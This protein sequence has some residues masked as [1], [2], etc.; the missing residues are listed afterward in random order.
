MSAEPADPKRASRRRRVAIWVGRVTAAFAFLGGAWAAFAAASFPSALA[1][2]P[3]RVQGTVTDTFIN[4]F[5]GDPAVDYRYSVAGRSYRGWGTG[6]SGYPDLLSLKPGDGIQVFYARGAPS[7]SCA[8]NPSDEAAS[9]G[10]YL[11]D[12]AFT[13]PLPILIARAI[14][15][16]HR[17]RARGAAT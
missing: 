16:R 15:R 6:G 13:L 5:G 14:Q 4:G 1:H 8:C 11:V 10:G 7:K 2:D 9:L 12:G 17:H 3:V